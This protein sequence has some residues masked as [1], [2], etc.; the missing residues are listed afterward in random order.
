MIP[1]TYKCLCVVAGI[2]LLS[3]RPPLT[4]R[5]ARP[6]E[7]VGYAYAPGTQQLLYKEL[8]T[9]TFEGGKNTETVTRYVD[10]AGQ[11][12]L[13]R[14]LHYNGGAYTPDVTTRNVRT[15][16]EAGATVHGD[17]IRLFVR[18]AK[19]APLR[20]KLFAMSGPTVIDYGFNQLVKDQWASLMGGHTVVFNYMIPSRLSYYVF[21]ITKVSSDAS[22]LV[23][24]MEPNN[25]LYRMMA[26][27]IIMHYDIAT[28]R[29]KSYEGKSNMTDAKGDILTVRLVYPNEGM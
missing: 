17:S 5:L 7:I 24:N 6:D 18:D 19:D 1:L 22:E 16:N 8:T 3:L 26:G 10:T 11:L 27:P 29:I 4:D 12:I 25:A 2:G 15:G 20:E 23:V 9:Q 14:T 21:R 28:K 13:V